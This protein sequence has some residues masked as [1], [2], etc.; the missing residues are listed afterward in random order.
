LPLVEDD[1]LRAVPEHL[2]TEVAEVLLPL[3]DRREVVARERAGLARERDVAV[4]HQELRL[5]DAA[6]EDDQLAGA[7]VA[8]RVLGA[9]AEVQTAPRDPAALAA[10]AHVDDPRLERQQRAERGDGLRRVLL[11]EARDEL[12]ASCGDVQHQGMFAP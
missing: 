6:W 8:R 10:P 1:V 7:R 2:S 3:D 11:L 4:R 5:A 12:E 9:E